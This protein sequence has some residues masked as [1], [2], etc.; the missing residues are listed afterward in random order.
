MTLPVVLL[1]CLFLV[2]WRFVSTEYWCSIVV[3]M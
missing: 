1:W 2:S 3:R